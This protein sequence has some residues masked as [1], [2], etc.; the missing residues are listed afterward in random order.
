MDMTFHISLSGLNVAARRLAITANNIA[1]I[2]TPAYKSRQ[3]RLADVATGG[4]KI[5]NIS[6]NFSQ[7]SLQISD[8]RFSLAIAGGGFFR[9][10]TPSGIRYT[11]AGNFG[12]DAAGNIVSP[13]GYLLLPQITVPENTISV[14]VNQQG[15]VFAISPDGQATQI[16]QIYIYRFANPQ[17][18]I[19]EG[20]NL[21]S[22]SS[23][24]GEP[25]EG[26]P[27]Q[28]GFG[29]ILFGYLEGSN[30]ELSSEMVSL[31]V[32]RAFFRANLASLRT[33]DE[34]LGS[35]FDVIS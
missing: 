26:L 2:S 30:V 19:F 33:R 8:G 16:G 4:V 17:G 21:V 11:R 18:L 12:I 9:L 22:P 15:Q 34:L 14:N 20:E 3:A 24:S 10:Q 5:S 25:V 27:Q 7:G 31:L 35:L 28:G 23:A 13:E 32:N 1:N 6:V 29:R